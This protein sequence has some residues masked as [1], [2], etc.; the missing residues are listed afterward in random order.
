L[1]LWL[2]MGVGMGALMVSALLASMAKAQA[3][4]DP[5]AVISA[6][7]LA[8]NRRDIDTALAYFADDATISQ[9]S[10]TFAGK[11][12]IRKFLDGISARSRFVVVS[13]R[14]V[15]GNR[16]TWSERSGTQGPSP[17]G[18]PMSLAQGQGSN[19]GLNGNSNSFVV[20]IE[21]VVQDGKIRSLAY[22]TTSPPLR[23]D[24]TL[25]GRAQ[26]PASVGLGAVVAVLFSVLMLASVSLSRRGTSP[27][28]LQGR[29]MHDLQGWSAA[30][31]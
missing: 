10:T 31:Q 11:D 29:L 3:G 16:V 12:D 25:D 18:Q 21:A 27:S 6:Y 28:S 2:A 20:S 1:R 30:R 8:R 22:L 13:D 24:S 19:G 5:A 17:Q 7:E 4:V 14:R 23:T 26:L 15:S 9:R